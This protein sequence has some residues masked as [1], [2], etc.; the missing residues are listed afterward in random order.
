MMSDIVLSNV[1]ENFSLQ[2]TS[3][4]C[5]PCPHD[6]EHAFQGP[7]THLVGRNSDLLFQQVD[8]DD[9]PGWTGILIAFAVHN[10]RLGLMLTSLIRNYCSSVDIDTVNRPVVVSCHKSNKLEQTRCKS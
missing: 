5:V 1:C 2:A 9:I 7:D 6:T 8:V 4:V 3:L 10:R